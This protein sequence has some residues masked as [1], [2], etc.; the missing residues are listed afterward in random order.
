MFK[1]LYNL[2]KN[3]DF[4]TELKDKLKSFTNSMRSSIRNSPTPNFF[5]NS[6]DQSECYKQTNSAANPSFRNNL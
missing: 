5:Y 1:D 2:S 6:A 4:H 3:P